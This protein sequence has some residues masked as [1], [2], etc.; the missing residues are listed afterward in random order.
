MSLRN[1]AIGNIDDSILDAARA[2]LVQFGVRRTTVSEVARRAGVSR[3]TVYRR[4]PDSDRLLADLLTRE[5]QQVM[6]DALAASSGSDTRATLVSTLSGGAAAVRANPVFSSL[7]QTDPE[8]MAT[9]VFQRAGSSQRALLAA[10]EDAV[11]AGQRDGSVRDGNPAELA[12]LLLLLAQSTVQSARL[13]AEQ[14]PEDRL[15]AELAHAVDA[16]LR[17]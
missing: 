14:L 13:V 16:Y 10:F 11:R 15:T 9:Y 5:L 4:W 2:C 1:N 12:G 8:L 3:P 17:P 7:F 6:F